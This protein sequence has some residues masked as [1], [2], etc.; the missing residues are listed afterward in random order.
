[1]HIALATDQNMVPGLHVTLYSLLKS[2]EM[3]PNIHLVHKGLTGEQIELLRETTS[4][5][6][7]VRTFEVIPFTS[8]TIPSGISAFHGSQLA[9]SVIA[10]PEYFDGVDRFIWLDSDL[11]ITCSVNALWKLQLDE[12]IAAVSHTRTRHVLSKWRN[13]L[14]DAGIDDGHPHFNTG[15]CVVDVDEWKS[16]GVTQR[17]FKAEKKYQI[18]GGDQPLLNVATTFT[19]L[20]RKWNE[21]CYRSGRQPD[22]LGSKIWHMVGS[23]KPWD[24]GGKL[25]KSYSAFEHVRSQTAHQTQHTTDRFIRAGRL[26]RSYVTLIKER[27]RDWGNA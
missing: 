27:W 19:R 5:G 10:L 15:V 14:N 7:E 26:S 9:F 17:A 6:G 3:E 4:R 16:R 11:I 12:P 18:E 22:L 8:L 2:T 1:M 20:P 21:A 23:P 24:V 25:H 13:A